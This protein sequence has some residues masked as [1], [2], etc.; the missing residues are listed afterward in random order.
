MRALLEVLD[1]HKGKG[2]G[3]W[4]KSSDSESSDSSD[5][6]DSSDGSGYGKGDWR[7]RKKLGETDDG[8]VG[9]VD[10][11]GGGVVDK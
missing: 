4:S 2:A 11:N 1:N 7:R 10:G 6:G 5:S 9:S 3:L 8:C